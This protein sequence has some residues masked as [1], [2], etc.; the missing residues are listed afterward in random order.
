MTCY[1]PCCTTPIKTS[2]P[3]A[4]RITISRGSSCSS[5]LTPPADGEMR[6]SRGVFRGRSRSAR[7]RRWRASA[8]QCCSSTPRK[9]PPTRFAGSSAASWADDDGDDRPVRRPGDRP[10][11]LH[12]GDAWQQRMQRPEPD[13]QFGNPWMANLVELAPPPPVPVVAS[14]ARPGTSIAVDPDR[15]VALG[16]LTW[17]AS[18]IGGVSP[19]TGA[20]ALRELAAIRRDR[21]LLQLSQSFMRRTAL[22]RTRALALPTSSAQTGCSFLDESAGMS[23]FQQIRRIGSR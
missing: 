4:G 23:E 2:I 8:F 16:R 14:G 6:E 20:E 9:I 5:S 21:R 15:S 12:D 18:C 13:G 19:P 10:L 3:E 7:A 1:A 17:R 22:P 11:E